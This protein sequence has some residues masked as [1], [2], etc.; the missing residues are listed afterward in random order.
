MS[1]PPIELIGRLGEYFASKW[2]K[3]QGFEVRRFEDLYLKLKF[4]QL[5]KSNVEE[6]IPEPERRRRLEQSYETRIPILEARLT[7]AENNPNASQKVK[8][9]VKQERPHL[10]YM[11][12]ARDDLKAGRPLES[13]T[14]YPPEYLAVLKRYHAEP[15]RVYEEISD[16]DEAQ[17][18]LGGRLDDFMKYTDECERISR[19]EL[20]GSMNPDIVAKKAESFYLV[21]VK[22]NTG[23]LAPLQ[24]RALELAG[25]YGFETK[26]IRVKIEPSCEE[27]AI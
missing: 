20:G 7:E 8:N 23:S 26:V 5:S 14:E 18:F 22:A 1:A 4:P 9:W 19:A 27:E 6:P 10:E 24:R 2:L 11:K 16:K 17:E 3:N 21:E 15:W 13:I 12:K 25:A